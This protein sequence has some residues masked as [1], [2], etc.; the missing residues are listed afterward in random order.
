M[1]PKPDTLKR[2]DPGRSD[3][4]DELR[5][6][7][8]RAGGERNRFEEER[9]RLIRREPNAAGAP[10]APPLARAPPLHGRCAPREARLTAKELKKFPHP[11]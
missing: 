2:G 6:E 3:S 8:L 1:A 4:R 9:V 10:E 5:A 7:H 11:R